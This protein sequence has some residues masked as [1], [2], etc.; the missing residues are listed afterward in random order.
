MA[1]GGRD[2]IDG[3]TEAVFDTI[4][5]LN[6]GNT[7]FNDPEF[8]DHL[9]TCMDSTNPDLK[10]ASDLSWNGMLEYFDSD[11]VEGDKWGECVDFDPCVRYC[12]LRIY[13]NDIIINYLLCSMKVLRVQ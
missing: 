6:T 3:L 13:C 10:R 9:V 7:E 4:E 12:H 1:G 11:G 8:L 5:E 2:Y